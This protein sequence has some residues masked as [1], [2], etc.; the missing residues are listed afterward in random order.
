MASGR[1]FVGPELCRNEAYLET[2]INYTVDMVN[3][4]LAVMCLPAWRRR[5]FSRRLPEVK[6]LF[7]R[8]REAEKFLG[9]IVTARREATQGPDYK[10]PD[11][12]LQWFI[13]AQDT[14]KPGSRNDA[15][16]A[17]WQL[18]ASFTAIHTTTAT[19]TNA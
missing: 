2:A 5:F 13:D 8:F 6:K 10:K 11:D 14:S 16:L 18:G 19:V 4:V 1:V 17:I 7:Q 12:M 3:A 9:P 15:E